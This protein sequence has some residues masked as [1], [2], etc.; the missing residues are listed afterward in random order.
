MAT[1]VFEPHPALQKFPDP[2]HQPVA[3]PP[4][5]LATAV[6]IQVTGIERIDGNEMEYLMKRRRV[7]FAAMPTFPIFILEPA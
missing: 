5:G 3:V 7:I 4:A 6:Q 2:R 1:G